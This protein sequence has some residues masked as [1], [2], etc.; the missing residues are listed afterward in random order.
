MQAGTS[1][2]STATS[3]WSFV[4]W[5]FVALTAVATV[6]MGVWPLVLRS[7]AAD[8]LAAP[9]A[10][11]FAV[12]GMGAAWWVALACASL[13]TLCGLIGLI[14]P[15]ARTGPAWAALALNAAFVAGSFALLL[16]LSP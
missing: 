8:P 16:I 15:D 6:A 14:S 7:A 10:G 11:V 9:G 3:V 13:G 4:S 1:S 2:P 12:V 5:A